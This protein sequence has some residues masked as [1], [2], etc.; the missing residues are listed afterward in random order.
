MPKAT[1]HPGYSTAYDHMKLAWWI[2]RPVAIDEKTDSG[3]YFPPDGQSFDT[4]DGNIQFHSI[5]FTTLGQLFAKIAN[6]AKV[7]IQRSLPAGCKGILQAFNIGKFRDNI[8]DRHS[9]FEQELN[10][11]WLE[12]IKETLRKHLFA[13]GECCHSIIS[14]DGKFNGEAARRWTSYENKIQSNVLMHFVLTCGVAP[15]EWQIKNLLFDLVGTMW[16]NMYILDG[17]LC[18]SDLPRL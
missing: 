8:S 10:K 7:L 3:F 15:R 13:P 14:H 9:V 11:Q 16:R 12:P 1:D 6:D 18:F 5:Q 2:A 17:T 4:R